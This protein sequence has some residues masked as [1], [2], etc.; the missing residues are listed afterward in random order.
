MNFDQT[1]T[2]AAISAEMLAAHGLTRNR[3][4]ATSFKC[5]VSQALRIPV[6]GIAYSH[7]CRIRRDTAADLLQRIHHEDALD[8]I[9]VT[10]RPGNCEFVLIDGLHRLL[11]SIAV[12][13]P[14]IPALLLSYEKATQD[15]FR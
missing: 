11:V 15:G 8:P 10:R 13:Y 7:D 2:I 12:G 3:A 14:S 5:T 6:T 1:T 4:A 9:V